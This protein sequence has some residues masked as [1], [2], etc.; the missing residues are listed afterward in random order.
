MIWTLITFNVDVLSDSIYFDYYKKIVYIFKKYRNVIVDTFK[1]LTFEE[2]FSFL[3]DSLFYTQYQKFSSSSSLN[4][5]LG[6]IPTISVPIDIPVGLGFL[7][8]NEA[9]DKC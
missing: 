5:Q 3:S 2:Y 4:N 1:I 9:N 8:G 7:G 6:L